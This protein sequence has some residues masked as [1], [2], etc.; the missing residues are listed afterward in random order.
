MWCAAAAG[1]THRLAVLGVLALFLLPAAPPLLTCAAVVDFDPSAPATSL[2]LEVGERLRLLPGKSLR[3]RDTARDAAG[4]C[5]ESR[6]R[7]LFVGATFRRGGSPLWGRREGAGLGL[8]QG[9]GLF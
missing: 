4:Q 9:H 7:W 5:G 6:R 8:S 1:W 2:S 3:I